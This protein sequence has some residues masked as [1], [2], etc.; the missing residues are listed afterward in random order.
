MGKIFLKSIRFVNESENTHV[1]RLG[2]E[3]ILSCK[4][5]DKVIIYH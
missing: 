5:V 4:L 3:N 2:Y 1:C